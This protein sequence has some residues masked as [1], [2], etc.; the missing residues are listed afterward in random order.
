MRRHSSYNV[1]L[2]WTIEFG[3]ISRDLIRLSNFFPKLFSAIEVR[4]LCEPVQS[5]NIIF[6]IPRHSSLRNME[7]R[8]VILEVTRAH[9]IKK[10]Q[11]WENF[12]IQNC[13]VVYASNNHQWCHTVV[14][15]TPNTATPRLSNFLVG[16]THSDRS[17]SPVSRH[18][19]T[20][21]SDQNSGEFSDTP[22][23]PAVYQI[24]E[25]SEH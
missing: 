1:S 19:H 22:R 4:T 24:S 18:T 6:C 16:T 14:R 21:P 7:T 10:P 5:A 17:R 9:S 23:I 13:T 3:H 12:I 11:C 2:R 8:I 25:N 15:E 20:R